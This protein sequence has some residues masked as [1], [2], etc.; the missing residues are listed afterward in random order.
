MLY[1]YKSST[2]HLYAVE[3]K[4]CHDQQAVGDQQPGGH[5]K[6][7]YDCC[8]VK[9]DRAVSVPHPMK[10]RAEL[11]FDNVGTAAGVPPE[12]P[13]VEV[14]TDYHPLHQ[15][16]GRFSISSHESEHSLRR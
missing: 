6:S 7:V 15:T 8:V 9:V 10:R 1:C 5:R 12:H 11:K 4:P 16:N 2:H 14:L 13:I 3:R